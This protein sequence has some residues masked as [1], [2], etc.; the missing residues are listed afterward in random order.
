MVTCHEP[1]KPKTVWQSTLPTKGPERI[2]TTNSFSALEPDLSCTFVAGDTCVCFRCAYSYSFPYDFEVDVGNLPS[3]LWIEQGFSICWR[4]ATGAGSYGLKSSC[5]L[6]ALK[7]FSKSCEV[8]EWADFLV[9][10]A[11][12]DFGQL[13]EPP[14]M[15]ATI[16]EDQWTKGWTTGRSEKTHGCQESGHCNRWGLRAV[17]FCSSDEGAHG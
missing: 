5:L 9:L 2:Q 14:N 15:P 3:L 10:L 16:R 4:P 8:W 6:H 12:R 7:G 17:P 1:C 11:S 13:H